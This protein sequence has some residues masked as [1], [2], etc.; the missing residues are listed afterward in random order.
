MKKIAIFAL[1]ALSLITIVIKAQ[2][3]PQTIGC[4]CVAHVCSLESV[5]NTQLLYMKEAAKSLLAYHSQKNVVKQVQIG[6]EEIHTFDHYPKGDVLDRNTHYQYYYHSHRNQEHGHFHTFYMFPGENEGFTHLIAISMDK[7]GRAIKLFTVNQ[8][9]TGE[10]WLLKEQ[11]QAKVNNFK[12]EKLKHSPINDWINPFF[13][14]FEPQINELISLRDKEI[15]RLK[16]QDS[17]I[18]QNSRLEEIT[19]MEISIDEQIKWLKL[20]FTKRQLEW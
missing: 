8:W 5:P 3:S 7:W 13:T 16:A 17:D 14:L 18:L 10:K 12:V 9:V 15:E 4:K 20:E 1:V 19:S 2:H 11:L 6:T